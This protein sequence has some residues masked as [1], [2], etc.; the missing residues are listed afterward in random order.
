[1]Q[2]HRSQSLSGSKANVGQKRS[3]QYTACDVGDSMAQ[4]GSSEM[5][6][7]L[8]GEVEK[9]FSLVSRCGSNKD[10]E[11][12]VRFKDPNLPA[13]VAERIFFDQ[14]KA[15]AFMRSECDAVTQQTQGKMS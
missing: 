1:M 7:E 12:V 11:F 14:N 5:S 15:Q 4:N 13:E 8:S 2:R 9:M 6:I 3:R 10:T